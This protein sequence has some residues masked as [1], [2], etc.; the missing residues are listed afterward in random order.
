MEEIAKM[1]DEGKTYREIAEISGISYQAAWN[2]HTEFLKRQRTE[3]RNGFSI[4]TIPYKGFYEYFSDNMEENLR[5]FSIKVRG[6]F[7]QS[8]YQKIKNTLNGTHVSL[9]KITD[10]EKMCEIT[11]KTFEELFTEREDQKK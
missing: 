4:K 11:G 3:K 5:T 7:E 8:F 6:Y 1:H 10:I 9:F 2:K